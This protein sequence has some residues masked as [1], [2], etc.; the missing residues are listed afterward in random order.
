MEIRECDF[1]V[2]SRISKAI[3]NLVNLKQVN[4]YHCAFADTV[5]LVVVPS[6]TVE[7]LSL[8]NTLFGGADLQNAPEIS[9]VEIFRCRIANDGSLPLVA[10]NPQTSKVRSMCVRKLEFV[11]PT[12]GQR[13][14]ELQNELLE[15]IKQLPQLTCLKLDQSSCATNARTLGALGLFFCSAWGGGGSGQPRSVLVLNFTFPSQKQYCRC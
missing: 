14:F 9:K 4:F 12:S 15:L 10:L 3:S 1:Q 2:T 8:T 6:K 11:E 7:S 5:K 13:K